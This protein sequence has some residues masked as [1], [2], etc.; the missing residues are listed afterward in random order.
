M[1]RPTW[2]PLS[3][4]ELLGICAFWTA[5]TLSTAGYWIMPPFSDA[6]PFV[7]GPLWSA[8]FEGLLWAVLTPPI[9][10]LAARWTI[11]SADRR[12]HIVLLL[13]TGIAL[14]L[15]VDLAVETVRTM[16]TPPHGPF[17]HSGAPK[18]SVPTSLVRP[19]RPP[20]PAGLPPGPPRPAGPSPDSWVRVHWFDEF[21]IYMAVLLAGITRDYSFRHRAREEEA[22]R[23]KA[24]ADRLLAELADARV[25]A[26]RA[27][28]NPHFLF[29]TLHAVSA[30]LERDA[31]GAR[32]MISRLSALLR[33]TLEGPTDQEIPL[34]HEVQIVRLYFEIVEIRFEDRIAT[35]IDIAS[36]VE[37]ALVPNFIL[38]PLV[39]NAMMHGLSQSERGGRIDV[40]AVRQGDDLVV[41]VR[42]TGPDVHLPPSGDGVGLRSTRGRLE[43]LYGPYQRFVLRPAPDGGMVAELTIPYHT[44]EDVRSAV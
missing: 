29:N 32:R 21:V 26:L 38:Q 30:L 36:D 34:S 8:V 28:L 10:W 44:R 1:A 27:Q 22:L 12:R 23:L 31:G 14:T 19:P 2:T 3:R 39:E 7:P 5:F 40:R 33:M 42:D 4:F 18:P 13:A 20:E 16:V 9:F 17:A 43:E 41:T 25:A 24:S 15:A 37:D 11:D 6:R 35:G